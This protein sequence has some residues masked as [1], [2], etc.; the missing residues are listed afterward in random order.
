M[1]KRKTHTPEFK[2]KVAL[3]AIREEMTLAELS[4]KYGVHPNQIS[5]WKRAAIENM[6]TAFTRRGADPGK[7]SEAEIEKL[8]SKIGQ[9][10]VERDFLANASVQP[11]R[12]ARQKMVSKDHELSQR[13]QCTL[14]QLSRSTLYYQPK[15]E[16]AEN[17]RFMEI[18]D[19]QFLETPW[20]GS[21][22]MARHMKRK[23][24]KCGRHRVR[25]LMR[26]MR[27]VPIYQEPNTSKKHPAHKIYPYL[28]KGL[29]ITRPNQVWCAD[30]TYIRMERGFLYLVAIMDW[31]SRKVLAWRLSNT[32]EADFCVAALK[33]PLA[34]YGPPEIF[35]TDQ[36]SQ[37][38]SSDWIDELKKAKVKISMDGKGRWI[39]NRMIERLWRSLKYECVYLRAF[40]TGSQARDGIGKWLAYYN[41]ERPHSTHGIL[42]PDEV[43]ANKTEPM[44]M[45][46]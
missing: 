19:K 6:A 8:H 42:T 29:A 7:G 40:E 14:L 39:D 45:A 37:F 20:Y 12:D 41:A 9:L 38:T 10:V 28:L 31:Y 16:S 1:A 2:A 25:R 3:E 26:L 24:H 11:A 35:N 33:E 18:I 17:L 43:H 46:A 4:K 21:R 44:K 23:G 32:L 13:R 36:G 22:Q 5:T 34:K 15:G 30:I 27:L